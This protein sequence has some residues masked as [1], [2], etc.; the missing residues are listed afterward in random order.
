M[1]LQGKKNC[2][3]RYLEHQ[4]SCYVRV[5]KMVSSVDLDLVN[6]TGD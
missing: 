2:F 1:L 6:M 3:G 4:T 5:I